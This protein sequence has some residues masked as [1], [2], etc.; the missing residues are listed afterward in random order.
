M[1]RH[2]NVIVIGSEGLDQSTDQARLRTFSWQDV[3]QIPN[4]SDADAIVFNVLTL[5]D[6]GAVDW[7][8]LFQALTPSVAIGDILAH[9]GCLIFLG[10]PQFRVQW[11]GED[12]QPHDDPF[13]WWTGLHF[14]WDN[15]PGESVERV[16]IKG[17][18]IRLRNYLS[19]L[20][21]YRYSL[22]H[23]EINPDVLRAFL[24]FDELEKQRRTIRA[25]V[26]DLAINRY[27]AALAFTIQ[28]SLSGPPERLGSVLHS[29][30]SIRMLPGE[31][32]FL[33][34]TDL[35]GE[36]ALLQLVRDLFEID[37]LAL[38]PGWAKS[39]TIGGQAAVDEELQRIDSDLA[40][41]QELREQTI[42]KRTAIRQPLRLLYDIGSGLEEIVLSVLEELGASVKKP[43]SPGLEDGWISVQSG[44]DVFEGVLEIK[45]TRGR[46]FKEDGLKQVI[47]WVDRGIQREMK[48]YKGIFVGNANVAK[49]PRQ[50]K[51]AFSSGFEKNAA[52]HQIV[53]VTSE[54]LFRCLELKR[55][56]M[57]DV[58]AFWRGLFNTNGL[59]DCSVC[60][61][62]AE[63]EA[64]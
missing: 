48:R 63:I 16:P 32:V 17:D 60:R 2:Q 12:G 24:N 3:E 31:L 15:R 59:Y 1:K 13:L 52:L 35:N 14:D 8:A 43:A 20:K 28:L 50:R 30:D 21:S 26:Q 4:L 64:T 36:D 11:T 25:H 29:V 41:L 61:K 55:A 47:T 34:E 9:G 62:A 44:A 45:G 42:E 39:L 18:L 27:N 5:A 46:Q 7:L 6:P 51:P 57:L 53:A 38:E 10:D 56:G 37:V 19:R 23:C 54:D 22:R 49:P 40:A 33:P 58:H